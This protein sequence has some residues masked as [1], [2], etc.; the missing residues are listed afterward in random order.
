MAL[1]SMK[2][3]ENEIFLGVVHTLPIEIIFQKRY[4]EKLHFMKNAKYEFFAV[5]YNI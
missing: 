1:L 4:F 3:G 2:K 5:S